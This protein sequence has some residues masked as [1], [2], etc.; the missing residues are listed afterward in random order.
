[1]TLEKLCVRIE[2]L[3]TGMKRKDIYILLL[4]YLAVMLTLGVFVCVAITSVTEMLA[5]LISGVIV[6]FGLTVVV[7][8]SITESDELF[9]KFRNYMKLWWVALI[10]E[11]ALTVVVKLFV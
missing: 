4:E 6:V 5:M 2:G 10:V 1:M 7:L 11:V 8:I 9:S 3:N